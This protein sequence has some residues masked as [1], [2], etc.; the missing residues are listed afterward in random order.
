VS[1]FVEIE[2]GEY[3]DAAFSGFTASAGGFVIGNARAL[4][5]LAQLAYETPNRQQFRSCLAN[6]NF[7]RQSRS[8]N[9]RPG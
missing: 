9:A 3:D 7:H 8:A 6:G 2:P 5:W 1:T 4:M